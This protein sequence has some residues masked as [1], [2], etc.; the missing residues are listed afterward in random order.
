M[1]FLTAIIV[2]ATSTAFAA[3][4]TEVLNIKGSVSLN[5]LHCEIGKMGSQLPT[6]QRMATVLPKPLLVTS[7]NNPIELEQNRFSAA[8]CD[9]ATLDQLAMDSNQH[10]GFLFG[11]SIKITKDTST[12]RR[13]GN[14]ECYA[15]FT[16]TVVLDLGH[17]IVLTS[18]NVKPIPMTDCPA[19]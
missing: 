3:P 5:Q 10:F 19:I 8:G 9:L 17:N 15:R 6:D 4:K 11:V 7:G 16:E 2:L 18:G 1:N 12:S 13:A 14:G